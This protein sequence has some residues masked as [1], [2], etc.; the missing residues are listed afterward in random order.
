MESYIKDEHILSKPNDKKSITFP[1]MQNLLLLY[2]YLERLVL[3]SLIVLAKVLKNNCR[4]FKEPFVA[5]EP[6]VAD[7][8]IYPVSHL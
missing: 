3:F 5:P 6:Q 4:R 8:K 7:G 1:Q 2:P